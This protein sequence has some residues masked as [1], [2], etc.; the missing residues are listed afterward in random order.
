[1]LLSAYACKPG[2][3]S[4]EGVGWHWALQAAR[5]HDVWV[6]TWS[7]FRKAIEDAQK[8][9]EVPDNLRFVFYDLPRW[10]RPLGRTERIYFSLWQLFV[11]GTARRLHRE[12]GFDVVHHL[13]YVTIEMPGVLWSLGAPF[14]WGPVGGGQVPPD[15]LKQ[16][17]KG[18]WGVELIRAARK[19]FLMLNPFAR[20]AAKKASYILVS[21]PDTARLLI[22]RTAAPVVPEVEIGAV[23]PEVWAGKD[24]TPTP[25]HRDGEGSSAPRIEGALHEALEVRHA[26]HDGSSATRGHGELNG[27]LEVVWAGLMIPRKGPLL[28]LDVAKAL[29]Q[30]GV[31]FRLRMAGRGPWLEMV[32][33]R[34]QEMGLADVVEVVGVVPFEEMGNFYAGAGV[35]LFTSLQDT[36][37]TVLL[38]A[39]AHG[40][41]VV[42]LDHHGAAAILSPEWGVKVPISTPAKTIDDMATALAEMADDPERRRRLGLAARRRVEQRYTWEHKAAAINRAYAVATQQKAP[43]PGNR[44]EPRAVGT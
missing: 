24:L 30:R 11:L 3:G 2:Y 36:N 21:N 25:L 43:A 34:V 20:L 6:L 27:R 12:V 41:P 32:R 10:V 31:D 39:M 13:N 19:R 15:A 33:A 40:L 5:E 14:V 8:A 22:N 4:E 42:S 37:G 17:Y 38:E 28:A 29:K 23:L 35:F 44:V 16:Y 26:A 7:K 9:G 1:V 18:F